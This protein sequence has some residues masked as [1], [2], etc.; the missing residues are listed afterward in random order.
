MTRTTT[1]D[2]ILISWVCSLGWPTVTSW[3]LVISSWVGAMSTSQRVVMPCSWGVKAGMVC[4]WVASKTVWSARY[5]RPISECLS[6]GA[7]QNKANI[8]ITR[9]LLIMSGYDCQNKC[10]SSVY[11]NTVSDEA[12]V[13]SSGRSR[14]SLPSWKF[15][16]FL[17]NWELGAPQKI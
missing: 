15:A 10:V 16:T 3:S 4:V 8:Q 2:Y 13:M 7:S 11:R 9:L 14:S 6:S 12:D 17:A 5:T 1:T